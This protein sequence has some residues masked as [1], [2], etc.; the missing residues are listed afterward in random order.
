MTDHYARFQNHMKTME[1]NKRGK[2][3]K[4]RDK[5]VDANDRGWEIGVGSDEKYRNNWDRIFAKK[6]DAPE[7]ESTT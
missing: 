2:V 7:N 3:S 4:M 6:S 5:I 1:S